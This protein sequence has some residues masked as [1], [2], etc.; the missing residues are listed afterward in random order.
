MKNLVL[1]LVVAVLSMSA[2]AQRDGRVIRVENFDI[3]KNPITLEA[4]AKEVRVADF[5]LKKAVKQKITYWATCHE[6]D[7]DKALEKRSYP[8]Q[9]TRNVYERV[10]RV[11][12]KYEVMV[13][14]YRRGEVVM[15][16]ETKRT[17]I[18]VMISSL[19][20][21]AKEM[22]EDRRILFPNKDK[23]RALA[24]ELFTVESTQNRNGLS[25]KLNR[26]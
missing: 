15:V 12:M 23:Y 26:N 16:Q 22:L 3:Y 20:T 11:K 9:Q 7:N 25:V 24:N 5:K 21:D 10:A 13:P 6:S 4:T 1:G 14:Y 2:S 19:P 18:N 8:C 17:M